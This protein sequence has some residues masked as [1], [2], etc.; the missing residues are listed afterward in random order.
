M[1]RL[2]GRSLANLKPRG[3]PRVHLAPGTC[4]E[5]DNSLLDRTL[6]I[7]DNEV[8]GFFQEVLRA[9]CWSRPRQ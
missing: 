2:D 7:G 5:I 6:L 9:P 3:V 8:P 4:C 1:R